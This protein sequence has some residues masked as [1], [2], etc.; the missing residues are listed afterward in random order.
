LDD[1]FHLHEATLY[2][3]EDL[4]AEYLRNMALANNGGLSNR[5]SPNQPSSE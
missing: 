4:L 5:D 3:G 2:F 1:N